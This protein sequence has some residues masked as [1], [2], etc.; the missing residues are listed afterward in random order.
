MKRH[1]IGQVTTKARAVAS[2]ARRLETDR[3]LAEADQ[4]GLKICAEILEEACLALAGAGQLS[5]SQA[6]HLEAGANG[7]L[8]KADALVHAPTPAQIAQ[9]WRGLEPAAREFVRAVHDLPHR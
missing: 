2:L 5:E 7:L 8:E 9:G 3:G 1:G 4:L 6:E